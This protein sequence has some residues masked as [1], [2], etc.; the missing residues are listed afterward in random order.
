MDLEGV[1]GVVGLLLHWRAVLWLF[2]SSVAAFLLVQHFP[3]FT[4]LQGV[5]LAALGLLPGAL[6]EDAARPSPS[7]PTARTS[8]SVAVLAAV[9]FAATWGT[10]SS[11]SAHSA[12]AG[13]LVFVGVAWGWYRFA[14]KSRGWLLREQGI[15]CTVVAAL[16]YP[17]A[18]LL[19]HNA[20]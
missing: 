3:W 11:A 14:V 20:F 1:L 10:V 5:V 7:S 17:L 8:T 12:G 16:A 19:A 15:L 2:I 6:W 18:A 4:G 9:V 13:A